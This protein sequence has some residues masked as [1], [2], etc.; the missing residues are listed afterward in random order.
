MTSPMKGLGASWCST[1]S[2]YVQMDCPTSHATHPSP[3]SI[4]NTRVRLS[5]TRQLAKRPAHANRATRHCAISP[6]AVSA[7]LLCCVRAAMT[8]PPTNSTHAAVKTQHVGDIALRPRERP[9]EYGLALLIWRT[10]MPGDKHSVEIRAGRKA[11]RFRCFGC[12]SYY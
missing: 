4:Q 8:Y 3:S 11:L 5:V 2:K 9:L 12:N 6:K 1:T 7:G 10:G